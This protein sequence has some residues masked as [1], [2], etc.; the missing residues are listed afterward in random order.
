[1]DRPMKNEFGV[2]DGG[3]RQTCIALTLAVSSSTV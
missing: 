1:M 2:P 3:I